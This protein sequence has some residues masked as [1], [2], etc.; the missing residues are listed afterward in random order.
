[1]TAFTVDERKYNACS[2]TNS[3]TIRQVIFAPNSGNRGGKSY[4]IIGS[5]IRYK[6][7]TMLEAS[8]PAGG[9]EYWN[10]HAP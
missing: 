9:P 7:H 10:T 5:S 6:G 8:G 1:M 3:G 2:N 4:C